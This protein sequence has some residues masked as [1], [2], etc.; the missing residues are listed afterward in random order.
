[1]KTIIPPVDR[2]LLEKELTQEKFVRDTNNGNNKIY[3]FSH[4]DSPNLMREIGRLREVTFRDAGGG[5]GKDCDIDDYDLSSKPFKQ[6]IVWNPI[7]KEIIG[8]YRF[9]HGKDLFDTADNN[10][11]SP[12][13]KLFYISDKF[14]DKYLRHTIELGRSFVQPL[15]QPINNIRKGMY[16]L[17]NI[18]DGLGA[19]IIDNPD[20]KYLFGKVTMYPHYNQNA[21]DILLYFLNKYFPDN[22]KLVY[23]KEP[24]KF[25]TEPEILEN[26]FTEGNF[27]DDYKILVQKIRSMKEQIPPLMNAYMNLS[28]TMKTFG[29]SVNK[30]FGDVEETGII[31]TI[32]DIFPKKKDRHFLTYKKKVLKNL[33]WLKKDIIDK[34]K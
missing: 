29:T 1:M 13:S 23:P 26:I 21:R 10:V 20:I 17:D 25:V 19:I 22:E 16:S 3:I 12:T 4:E 31:I 15:Y 30:T 6:M 14:K 9:I 32:K 18:W 27:N 28:A 2:K 7:D 11:V 8:G 33:E 24:I 5:S 34:L